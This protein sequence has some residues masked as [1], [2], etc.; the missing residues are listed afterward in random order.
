M[1]IDQRGEGGQ[2]FMKG[3]NAVELVEG[4]ESK[5]PVMQADGG[6]NID[7]IGK[8]EDILDRKKNQ[9][10]PRADQPL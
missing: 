5:A 4:R 7:L 1:P 9:T 3:R 10:R 8:A 2:L 6:G